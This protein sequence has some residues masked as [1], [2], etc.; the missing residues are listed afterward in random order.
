[1][2]RLF[3][4][5]AVCVCLLV[6][7]G[8]SANKSPSSDGSDSATPKA[9]LFAT[10]DKCSSCHDKLADETGLDTSYVILWNSSVHAYASVDP[11][12][13]TT[14]GHEIELFPDASA[15]IENSC[16]TCHLAMARVTAE[17]NGESTAF[18]SED[19]L[20]SGNAL[21]ALYK[22]GVS[23][24]VCHQI[25]PEGI[26][27][28][29]NASGGFKI[30]TATTGLRTL[31]GPFELDATDQKPMETSIKFTAQ[32]ET[33]MATADF[34]ATCHTLYTTPMTE[35][36]EALDA[37]FPEQVPVLEWKQSSYASSATCQSCHMPQGAGVAKISS[38]SQQ[39]RSPV[40]RHIFVGGNV[41]LLNLMKSDASSGDSAKNGSLDAGIEH[42]TENLQT[43]TASLAVSAERSGQT[44]NVAV[45]VKNLTGHKLP[46]S[47]PSRRA[48][49]H[50]VATDA[51]GKTLFESG[52]WKADGSITGNDNDEDASRFEPHYATIT[53]ADQVQ[54][55]EP[56]LGDTNGKITTSVIGAATYLKDNRLLPTGFDKSNADPDT[57][58][59][60][61]ALSDP[62]FVG[63]GD[64]VAYAIP[65]SSASGPLSVKV[66]FVYQS[67]GYRW[68]QNLGS[69]KTELRDHLFDLADK[70]PNTP[71]VLSSATAQ[72]P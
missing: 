47:F 7:S 49:L 67:I 23:C 25:S 9:A 30:D 18:V 56:I 6:L 40:S 36:G 11:Y 43:K 3:V 53:S 5:F 1:M 72:V 34:C 50:V 15:D 29:A 51:S 10:A 60:G 13:L 46:T 59:A 19:W 57:A 44:L 39:A 16:A 2:K 71:V 48:W 61:E 24:L 38:L 12:Y 21:H 37:K 35:D 26:G 52:A 33:H 17:A 14:V 55:Y 70:T 54:I 32:Q 31:F 68:L 45:D 41:F 42:T 8:C 4:W 69:S 66:E 63:G 62:D 65:L 64:R 28:E 58:V 22:D 20:D 27:T